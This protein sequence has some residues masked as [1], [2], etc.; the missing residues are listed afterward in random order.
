MTAFPRIRLLPEYFSHATWVAGADGTRSSTPPGELPLSP[1][2]VAEL[3]SWAET[4]HGILDL[5]DQYKTGF[6]TDL[7]VELFSR[8]GYALAV[9]V[10]ATLG[11]PV[12][13][14]D[15]LT[16]SDVLVE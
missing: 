14:F 4:Y 8:W 2:L 3:Q 11:E 12:L 7:E 6:K 13:Y 10:V 15:V 5:D 9:M 1:Y 16:N